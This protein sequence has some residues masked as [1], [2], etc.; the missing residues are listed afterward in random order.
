MS[1]SSQQHHGILQ[2]LAQLASTVIAIVHTRL[3]LLA[4][5]LEQNHR[6]VLSVFI[7]LLL[8]LLML[9]VALVLL[10]MLLILLMGEQHRLLT[11]SL[12]TMTFTGLGLFS[13]GFAAYKMHTK[14]AMFSSSL[15][16]LNKDWHAIKAQP[17]V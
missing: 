11:L 12:L 3:E 13:A 10:C 1:A 8:A 4:L 2:S 15:A 5:D 16:E 17:P 9:G 7:M 6:Y 14:P